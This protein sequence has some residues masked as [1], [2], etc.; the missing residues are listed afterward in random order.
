MTHWA[1]ARAAL[2]IMFMISMG[3]FQISR[4]GWRKIG[5]SS[6]ELHL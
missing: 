4:K 5:S 3:R 2:W 1:G 6:K